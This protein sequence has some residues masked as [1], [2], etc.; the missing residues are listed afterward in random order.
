MVR[1]REQLKDLFRESREQ[2]Q[3]ER[4]QKR[5]EKQKQYQQLCKQADQLL[6]QAIQDEKRKRMEQLQALVKKTP[7]KPLKWSVTEFYISNNKY[8]EKDADGIHYYQT[9]EE[10][11]AAEERGEGK[12]NWSKFDQLVSETRKELG[13]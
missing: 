1:T 13:L 4:Q 8:I 12:I 11:M 9:R 5:L 7:Q 6:K 10:L 2:K 3:K